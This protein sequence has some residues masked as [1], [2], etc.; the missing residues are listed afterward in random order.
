MEQQQ[1]IQMQAL[2][3]EADAL[4]QQLQMIEQNLS[5][6]QELKV[7]LEEIEKK[8]NKEILTNL[9]KRI[10]LPVEIKDKNLFV[11]VG[12]GNFVKKTI[13]ETKELIE[14]Q[15]KKLII[16]KE[17]VVRNLDDLQEQANNLMQGFIQKGQNKEEENEE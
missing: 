1:I 6:I 15:I 16:G 8:E 2:E 4:N 14:E 5:E 7:G 11:E 3:Q 17:D 9:G 10:Y 12:K 13:P